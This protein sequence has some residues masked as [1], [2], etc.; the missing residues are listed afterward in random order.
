MFKIFLNLAHAGEVH[1]DSA[2]TVGHSLTA[3]YIAV[4]I[5]LIAVATIGYL[6]W[7]VS[8]KKPHIVLTVLS[9]ALLIFG[10]TLF[11]ISA[12]VSVIAITAG[13]I[14]AGFQAFTS[15]VN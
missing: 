15:L 6:T 1:S 14:L 5:F 7:L 9:V 8:G 10:F 2:E 3:W 12:A 11:T 4:P 13:L